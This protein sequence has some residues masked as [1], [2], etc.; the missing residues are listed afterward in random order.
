MLPTRGQIN[1]DVVAGDDDDDDNVNKNN[2]ILAIS[3]YLVL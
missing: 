3:A 1:G 2:Y